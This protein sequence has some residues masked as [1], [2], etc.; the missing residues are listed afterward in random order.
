MIKFTFSAKALGLAST[1]LFGSSAFAQ[2]ELKVLTQ[3]ESRFNQVNDSGHG[4]TVYDYY[5]FETNALTPIESDAFAVESINNNDD[6][7]GFMIY[8]ETNF[9]LQAG[10]RKNDVWTGIGFLPAQDPQQQDELTTYKLSSNSKYITGQANI[11]WNFGGFLYDT[12]TEELTG[13]FDPEG[14]D[15]AYYAVNDNGIIGGWIDRPNQS[16]TL[17]VPAYRTL[18]G[19][20][21]LIPE[22]Q[23][24]TES[25]I[26]TINDINNS[27]IMVGAFNLHPFIYDKATNT[28]TSFEN[29]GEGYEAAFSSISDNGVAVGFV[30]VG[31]ETRDAII[32]HPSLGN[33]PI[34]LKDLLI[35]NGVAVNTNDGLLGTAIS[36]SPNGKYI[37]GWVNGMP[38]TANGWMLY[39]DDLILGTNDVVQN[40]LSIFPNPVE[41]I[42]NINTT[43]KVDSIKIFNI[44]GQQLSDVVIS[45]NNKQIDVSS[46]AAGVYMVNVIS[47]ATQETFKIIKQ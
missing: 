16:G 43:A 15:G 14:E 23:L 39:L 46:L 47:K 28:F 21:H 13:V 29:P 6:V 12:E 45:E 11:E 19:E 5:D 38:S 18:D 42:L 25:E 41:N 40:Q 44:L 3:T 33:Q 1:L 35:D 9:I 4:V 36:V 31:Y 2:I 20:F 17:R 8:D 24:P 26:N 27:D 30:E 10:F 7:A 37:A 22:G 34:F 32:Y